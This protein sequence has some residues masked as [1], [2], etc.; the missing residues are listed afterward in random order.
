MDKSDIRICLTGGSSGGHLFPLIFV[1]REIKRIAKSKGWNL[2]IFYLG[3]LPFRSEILKEEGIDIFLIPDVR[4]RKYFTFKN[5]VIIFNLPLNFL[6]AL[7]RLFIL[8]P[9]VIFSKG[10]P[11]T[12]GVILAGWFLRIPIIIHDSD[13]VPGLSNKIAGLFAKKIIL[14]FDSASSYFNSK[15]I[16]VLG[17]PVDALSIK[18]PVFSEDYERFHL[19]KDEKIILILG[20]SQGSVFV[21]ELVAQSLP[22]ILNFSQVVHQVGDKNYQET[23]SL[24]KGILMSSSLDNPAVAKNLLSKYHP[25]SFINHQDLIILMKMADL[26]ISRAGSGTIFELA[27]LAKPSILIPIE[28]KVAGKHQL[29]N[30]RIYASSGACYVLEEEN[31]KPHLLAEVIKQI[32]FNEELYLKMRKSAQLF[33]KIDSAFKIAEEIVKIIER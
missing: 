31:A 30:A 24:V 17:Q 25:Y 16:I 14:S 21:N 3:S 15:K 11:G 28:E 4:L 9:D 10:G 19:N 32:L 13:S 23:V 12:I 6:L 7:Y 27:A 26:V 20:G 2:R 5:L 29:L 1:S 33:S 18:L 8:M 22:E